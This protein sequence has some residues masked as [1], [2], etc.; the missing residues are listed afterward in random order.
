MNRIIALL[1]IAATLSGCEPEPPEAPA[2]EASQVS[3]PFRQDG[4]L[5]IERDGDVYLTLDIEIADT[6][7]SRSRGLMQRDGLPVDSGMWFIFDQESEQGFWMANTR[8][9][10]DLI[11]VRS[12]GRIQHIARYIQPMRT[13]TVPSNGPAQYVLEVEAGYSDSYGILE[14]DVIAF[15]RNA[16]GDAPDTGRP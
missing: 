4:T 9:A 1:F 12:D 5:T 10:L 16:G 13:E 14:G 11:F 3:I 8:M 7:S 15:E 2:D 6:D